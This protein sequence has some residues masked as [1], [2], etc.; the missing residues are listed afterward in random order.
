MVQTT[1]QK[2]ED[3]LMTSFRSIASPIA[4]VILFIAINAVSSL[5][6]KAVSGLHV[7]VLLGVNTR[8]LLLTLRIW[9][10]VGQ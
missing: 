6:V 1:F 8:A 10:L 4:I 9:S 3:M 2:I 5:T 7:D